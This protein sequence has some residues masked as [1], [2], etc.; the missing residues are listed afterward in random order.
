MSIGWIMSKVEGGGGPIDP[1]PPPF[2]ASCNYF[3]FEAS[4]F[5]WNWETPAPARHYFFQPQQV[6]ACRSV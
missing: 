1:P 4:I 2:K 6:H 5:T 3:F